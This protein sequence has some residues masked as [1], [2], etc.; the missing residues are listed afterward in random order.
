MT[1]N[2]NRA[3]QW[4]TGESTRAGFRQ[5]YRE[6]QPREQRHLPVLALHG[7]LTQ[8]GM[9]IALAERMGTVRMLCPD[10]RGYGASAVQPGDSCAEFTRDALTLADALLP[11]RFVVMGHSFACSIALELA[12]AAAARIAGVVQVDPVVRLP[13]SSQH[14][15]PLASHPESYA[16][17]DEAQRHFLT[18][19]EGEWTPAAL[20][21]FTRDVM[22][23]SNGAWRFPYTLERLR[24]L[25]TFT[26]SASG[27][28]D[29]FAKARRVRAPVLVFRGGMS[30]RFPAAAQA[31]F[32]AAFPASPQVVLCPKSGHFP[33]ATE[34]RIVAEALAAF[35]A[36]LR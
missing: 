33:T 7:S 12:N 25:R 27:D 16:T 32:A 21:R 22:I 24:R 2:D 13:G 23:E 36:P 9:W 3:G 11:G 28:Y 6:W 18:T 19:E 26:A 30:K 34:P 10:Q 31:P 29:L 35:L 8:S 17:L 4:R 1:E 15:A 20:A 5:F 14:P